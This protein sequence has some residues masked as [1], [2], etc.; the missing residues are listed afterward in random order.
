[1]LGIAVQLALSWLFLWWFERT[2]L[3]PL[4]LMPS[5]TRLYHFLLFFLISAAFCASGFGLKM[6]IAKQRWMLSPSATVLGFLEGARWT[7]V[8]VLFEELIFRGALLYILI[9]KLGATRAIWISA[10]AFGIYHWF[11]HGTLG[12]PGA[13]F[14]TFVITGAMGLVQAYGFAK[15]G[16]MYIPSA[17]HLGWNLVQQNV[18]SSSPI[19]N[20]LF[21][22]VLP[23]PEITV[24]SIA[25]LVMQLF[26]LLGVLGV[27]FWVIW[28][29]SRQVV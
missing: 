28:W 18:F 12:N 2:N 19:G 15:T 24:S 14:V 13:M 7:T 16:S 5:R 29:K 3:W 21:V 27:C 22:E 20:Q 11:S 6:L 10:T 4:G 23:H 17:I 9:R 1:M 26:S 8:S 25:Y